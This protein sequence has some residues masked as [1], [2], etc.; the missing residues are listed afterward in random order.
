VS[1]R[2]LLAPLLW[3]LKRGT[4]LDAIPAEGAGT[5][6]PLLV[7]CLHS[8]GCW[9]YCTGGNRYCLCCMKVRVRC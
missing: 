4:T 9:S 8:P 7:T 6:Q 2:T 1:W 3:R 5:V